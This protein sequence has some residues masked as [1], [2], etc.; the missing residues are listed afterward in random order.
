MSH[1]G[2]GARSEALG[3]RFRL[4]IHLEPLTESMNSHCKIETIQTE[5]NHVG[6]DVS[7]QHLD[8]SIAGCKPLRAHY[9]EQHLSGSL[10][11]PGID[12]KKSGPRM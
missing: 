2:L 1:L 5:T 9:L 4:R 8:V 3:R 6:I 11:E 7:K 12:R 10:G